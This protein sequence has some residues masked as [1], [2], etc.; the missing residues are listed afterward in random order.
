[1]LRIKTRL[2]NIGLINVHAPIQ[3]K[4]AFYQKVEEIYDSC[5]SN[6]IKIMLGDWNTK[7]G[8][9]EIY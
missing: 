5:P 9:K 8:R 1:V 2:Q 6:D 3:E 4:E 7:V